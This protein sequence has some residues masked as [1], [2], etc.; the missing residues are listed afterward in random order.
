M[1]R[2]KK[3]EF[4]FKLQYRLVCYKGGVARLV[5]RP[6]TGASGEGRRRRLMRQEPTDF[7]GVYLEL[8]VGDEFIVVAA[9]AGSL[10]GAA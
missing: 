2:R 10:V 8:R 3:I 5:C 4:L 1:R 7:V 6:R 9:A